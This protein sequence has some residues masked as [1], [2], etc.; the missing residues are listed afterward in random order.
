MIYT[1]EVKLGPC[2]D[3]SIS[4][5]VAT[6]L[7]ARAAKS[8][9]LSLLRAIS[10]LP[11]RACAKFD[12]IER[13]L[14]LTSARD[15]VSRV[16][17]VYEAELKAGRDVT[18]MRVANWLFSE[19]AERKV[20]S[21]WV[22]HPT[23]YFDTRTHEERVCAQYEVICKRHFGP[24]VVVHIR[25]RRGYTFYD[26][27]DA[28]T[29]RCIPGGH[30]V[31]DKAA[32]G[33]LEV[34]AINTF[35]YLV[36]ESI[37]NDYADGALEWFRANPIRYP[38]PGPAKTRSGKYS[39][40]I[41]GM[42]DSGT[43]PRGLGKAL[44]LWAD[45]RYKSLTGYRGNR[46]LLLN[47]Y[48][49]LLLE[50]RDHRL[51]I[52]ERL[53]PDYWTMVRNRKI[54]RAQ[55]QRDRD[56]AWAER[57]AD[58]FPSDD[59]GP[60]PL[61]QD[62]EDDM[63]VAQSG[64][65]D[66]SWID[67]VK[68]I[69]HNV[70]APPETLPEDPFAQ[71]VLDKYGKP[72]ERSD[73]A[74]T[75]ETAPAQA[76]PAPVVH[77][78]SVPKEPESK[79]FFKKLTT[80]T[81][82]EN[83]VSKIEALIAKVTAL[84]DSL[85]A[86]LHTAGSRTYAAAKEHANTISESTTNIIE[87]I[88]SSLTTL[89]YIFGAVVT[90]VVVWLI[91]REG[92]WSEA[93]IAAVIGIVATIA[94]PA[95]AR[96]LTSEAKPMPQAQSN[97]TTGVN[98][99][100]FDSI[101]KA[102][103]GVFTCVSFSKEKHVDVDEIAKKMGY[104]EKACSGWSAFVQW[105]VGAFEWCVNKVRGLFGAD[106]VSFVYAGQADVDDWLNRAAAF[107]LE[108]QSGKKVM[109]N[110]ALNYLNQLAEQGNNLASLNRHLP[111]VSTLIARTNT[112][113]S[114]LATTYGAALVSARGTRPEPVLF[115]MVGPPGC[116]KS[117]LCELISARVIRECVDPA[118]V[119][120][121]KYDIAAFVYSKSSSQYMEGYV[122]QPVY[123]LD[124]AFKDTVVSGVVENDS[125]HI[126]Q[127]CNAW[128][129]PLNMA[130][131]EAKGRFSMLARSIIC[132]T[133]S[134]DIR[135][136]VETSL[137]SPDALYRR[138]H[139]PYKI[140]MHPSIADQNK[141]FSFTKFLA[142]R[143]RGVDDEGYYTVQTPPTIDELGEWHAHPDLRV[144]TL[145]GFWRA[146]RWN[147][148][149]GQSYTE[150]LRS[151][152]DV[153][154]EY[155][156]AMKAKGEMHTGM[157]LLMRDELER[158]YGMPKDSGA[159]TSEIMPVAQADDGS[160]PRVMLG[161][162][163]GARSIYAAGNPVDEITKA[164]EEYEQE[165][166]SIR[167][168]WS[169][170]WCTLLSLL[171]FA[172]LAA[173]LLWLG[174]KAL[175]LF[176]EWWDPKH[177][178]TAD[179][180]KRTKSIPHKNQEALVQFACTKGEHA[181]WEV[182]NKHNAEV[183]EALKKWP[184][185]SRHMLAKTLELF[186]PEDFKSY[187]LKGEA[188][189]TLADDCLE[190][191]A[192]R[193]KQVMAQSNSRPNRVKPTIPQAH[194]DTAVDDVVA[195]CK[196][197]IFTL[198]VL[199]N[200]PRQLGGMWAVSEKYFVCP[201][202]YRK[203]LE[204]LLKRH[205]IDLDTPL[206]IANS[207]HPNLKLES[208][209]VK[210]FMTTKHSE[211]PGYDL[212]ALPLPVLEARSDIRR[213]LI[214][215]EDLNG[216]KLGEVVVH[217]PHL[218]GKCEI[219]NSPFEDSGNVTYKQ[220][221]D[222]ICCIRSFKYTHACY[223]GQCGAM[224]FARNY[225]CLQNRRLIG[226]HVC[227]MGTSSWLVPVTAEHVDQLLKQL[228]PLPVA[229]S[230]DLD[231]AWVLEGVPPLHDGNIVPIC[232]L[233]KAYVTGTQSALIRTDLFNKWHI[234]TKLPARLKPFQHPELGR[235]DP[236][237]NAVKPYAMKRLL[238]IPRAR[239]SRALHSA[240]QP[241]RT[242][243]SKHPRKVLTFEESCAGDPYLPNMKAINRRTSPGFPWNLLGFTSKRRF[244]GKEGPFDFSSPECQELRAQVEA[245]VENAR[246]NIR[247]L[248]VYTDTLKDELRSPEA[249]SIGKTRLVSGSPIVYVI[250]WRMYFGAWMSAWMD[251]RIHNG[252]C[253]GMN[254]HT[255][256]G[257]LVAHLTRRGPDNFAGDYTGYDACNQAAIMDAILEDVNRWYSDDNDHIRR[258]LWKEISH[259]VH[260]SGPSGDR[261]HLYQW[262]GSM[263]SGHPA[264]TILN[265][266]YNMI[267]FALCFEDAHGPYIHMWDHVSLAVFGDDN[268]SNV[269]K[270]V[271]ALFNQNTFVDLVA[272]YGHVYTPESK[273]GLANMPDTRPV[274]DVTFLKRGFRWD[275]E[276]NMWTP[277]LELNT[278]LCMPFY[279]EDK[280]HP[281]ESTLQTIDM[282]LAELSWH[283][284]ATWDAWA[285]KIFSALATAEPPY[286]P[287]LPCER[288]LWCEFVQSAYLETQW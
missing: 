211:L 256:W 229:Q 31:P 251:T 228:T 219:A 165:V 243:T 126:M 15:T 127:A 61:A 46:L 226:M 218:N 198:S 178:H 105:V 135:K 134:I 162:R 216:L 203:S 69:V 16:L 267:L 246:N 225:P 30:K 50:M 250:L 22:Q 85:S 217:Y 25:Q 179:F 103:G 24:Q 197:N 221:E 166:G 214:N 272:K 52:G 83:Q 88:K 112:T 56:Q 97:E 157:K 210:D 28:T 106:P 125:A 175:K 131:V 285:P 87:A 79:G 283:S 151:M 148:A 150:G 146:E 75:S 80:V 81:V 153:V 196:R 104:Y 201:L 172:V 59:E 227:G 29:F 191:A 119:A 124:D 159:S 194:A 233:P 231:P 245:A 193:H 242:L 199:S 224:G 265:S 192:E 44:P 108:I 177:S 206:T 205:E 287:R 144:K 93:V 164:R 241:F 222:T 176:R 111:R 41:H 247:T 169:S 123:V 17:T 13:R 244:F 239:I 237:L 48:R 167:S 280:R 53:C 65:T 6:A 213:F 168:W 204:Y 113:I 33:W 261:R 212:M 286:H 189:Y 102:I 288:H 264:T 57:M 122:A 128:P 92:K 158:L 2:R 118:E 38:E 14:G 39:A 184:P 282:A 270:D 254:P 100:V 11:D 274:T 236:F 32:R 139:F 187:N 77:T 143:Q 259:S 89:A 73:G 223:A 37:V 4:D 23:K 186:N 47:G 136:V 133:N 180:I 266:I 117:C 3:V 173:G 45:A 284:Q 74:S 149:T 138:L 181:S 66:A 182:T 275:E 43:P 195:K 95:A 5:K 156:A 183:L 263:P 121:A 155:I 249:V 276:A 137:S 84:G 160:L 252:C 63:P 9:S 279:T 54:E 76:A 12:A 34:A 269:A 260:L 235:V 185:E 58:G 90:C 8:R 268:S 171:G 42:V 238:H 110:A 163:E 258:I 96:W 142:I 71:G 82:D 202:H 174:S 188:D 27:R 101:G 120:A 86:S 145:L 20:E 60:V 55:D 154:V 161:R 234:Q 116:G 72:K 273:D 278:V 1:N 255:D 129:M 91:A 220:H 208:F 240:L 207:D 262:C 10:E 19:P 35:M 98:S 257:T 140:H 248:H 21:S 132:S 78:L 36:E 281:R 107:T 200:P 170:H 68:G 253:V 115:L 277:P 147:F 109:D 18:P 152:E 51:G 99:G 209:T 130:S 26:V 114:S 70:T 94:G 190:K 67:K 215:A 49:T 64:V 62:A 40:H 230:C 7:V 141:R 271:S 232:S